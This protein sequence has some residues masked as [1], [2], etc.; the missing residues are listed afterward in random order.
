M[1]VPSLNVSL[2]AAILVV[3]T[4]LLSWTTA[5][6]AQTIL[7]VLLFG[8][9]FSDEALHFGLKVGVNG[10]TTT[11]V[12]ETS[13]I[14]G[15]NY[16]VQLVT[17]LDQAG[18]W[19]LLPEISPLS[20]KGVEGAGVVPA[21]MERNPELDVLLDGTTRT[22][23]T[24]NFIDLPLVLSYR[25]TPSLR[26]GAGPYLGYRTS[27]TSRFTAAA[28]PVGESEIS[29][30]SSDYYQRW[31]YGAVIEVGYSFWGTKVRNRPTLLLRYQVGF[32]DLLKDNPGD[33]I[34]NRTLQTSAIFPY[35]PS[36]DKDEP[37]EAGD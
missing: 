9:K 22:R 30:K 8:P 3:P 29:K 12:D 33:A 6:Q 15:F 35:L 17:R 31:D 13:T 27:A 23:T 11:G 32:S 26:V 37:T 24:F 25:P 18:K 19:W 16:G 36:P 20:P 14:W 34:R 2:V 21:Y 7:L 5:L 10:A 4:L 1:R 28:D